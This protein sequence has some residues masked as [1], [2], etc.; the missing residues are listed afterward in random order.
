MLNAI[1]EASNIFSGPASFTV[2]AQASDPDGTVA[3]V[4]FY[5][6]GLKLREMTSGPYA[7]NVNN[8]SAGN[9]TFSVK[10]TDN[11]LAT[12]VASI[13]ITVNPPPVGTG[14]GLYGE[15]YDN[16]DFTGAKLTR[17][18]PTVNFNWGSGSPD[19]SMAPDQFSVR[20]TG[21]VQPRLSETYT[22]HTL[23]DDGVRL[24]VNRVQVINNWTDHSPAE[25]TAIHAGD[26]ILTFDFLLR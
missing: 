7:F 2:S 25:T 10:V 8:L 16:I 13:S 17:L 18:D 26:A 22:F 12:A 6:D 23:S 24:W 14:T 21:S 1:W 19:P 11:S 5:R 15:Y 4:E 3:R 20:W 9:Y